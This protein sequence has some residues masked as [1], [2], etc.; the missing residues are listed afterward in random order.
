[1]GQ[2]YPFSTSPIAAIL[3]GTVHRRDSPR[4]KS[5]D[6]NRNE[7]VMLQI[8]CYLIALRHPNPV[9]LIADALCHPQLVLV[10]DDSFLTRTLTYYFQHASLVYITNTLG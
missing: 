1:M 10:I 5:G 8:F 3:C 6:F 9:L 7:R 4:L 2:S